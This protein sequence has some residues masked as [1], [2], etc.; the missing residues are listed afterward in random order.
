MKNPFR[1]ALAKGLTS[2]ALA[3]LVTA[4]A[5][6][7]L[8]DARQMGQAGQYESAMRTLRQALAAR[9]DDRELRTAL[10]K[11]QE[12]A[13]NELSQQAGMLRAAGQTADAR[14][15]LERLEVVAPQHP[16]TAALRAELERAARLQGM[17]A[18]G[19]RHFE[20]ARYEQAEATL[21]A[22]LA[23]DGANHAAR[24]LLTRIDELR[25]SQT[26]QRSTLSL[27]TSQKPV[28]LEFRDAALRNVF[29]ALARAADLNFVFDKDVRADARLTLFLK[30]TTV[31]E[32][33]RVILGTQQLGHKL[34]NAN[35]VMVFPATQQKQRD[36]LDT[37][38]RTF[39][40][41]NADVKQA[42]ALVRTVAKSR[43]VFIDERLNLLVVRD[44]PEVVQLID[45]LV[46][47]LDLPDPE[48]VLDLEVMEVSSKRMS[49]I[50][51][52]WPEA[53]NYGL[54]GETGPITLS[55]NLNDTLR[56]Y[57]PNPLAVAQ[58]RATQGATNLL[59][60]PR[61]RARNREKAKVL[62]GEKLP[63][64]TTT[65]TANVGVSASVSYLD[66][67]LKLEIEPQVQLDND[68]T[69]KVALEVSS[70]TD[71]VTGPQ[72]SIAYQVG[73]RQASTTLRLKDGETQILAG[74]IN[75]NES[76]TA[77]GIPGLKDLP[78]AGRLFSTTNDSRDK[79]EVVLLVTPRIV[80]NIVQP[81]SA[82][83]P[84]PSGTESQPGA[85]PMQLRDMAM[86]S[87]EGPPAGARTMTAPPSSAP[88]RPGAPSRGAAAEVSANGIGLS[89]PQQVMPGSAFR[90]TVR[91]AGA[92][93]VNETVQFDP[94]YLEAVEGDRALSSIG[95]QLPA[96]GSATVML[97]AKAGLGDFETTVQLRSGATL[98]LQVK[99]PS[100]LADEAVPEPEGEQT[101]HE[102]AVQN[103]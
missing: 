66:V 65:S 90:L 84:L 21:R 3:L 92:Q 81:V 14:R 86:M 85:M 15:V 46:Q 68:V 49:Q 36:V 45:R 77:A 69:M 6:P 39:Y 89:G 42:Q 9:P 38:T 70:V 88:D 67:G 4:C 74:L 80:R 101:E 99:E 5:S 41:T 48:V 44:T 95:V 72:G 22:L 7:A 8:E 12:Q 13:V 16:R 78:L 93:P 30:N 73:T 19:R 55:R 97:R 103:P 57:V 91:N 54:P 102:P 98:R 35:T 1:L 62:L 58:L 20:A 32:A 23:E 10:F 18:E 71:K 56:Y 96:T 25:A 33:L 61:I 47:G 29:E 2:L 24:D 59:A 87:N 94:T 82:A 50:G 64:F 17:L 60:N 43:D 53:V 51:I 83:S 34:L 27:A 28:T 52:N 100:S 31:E 75:D 79:T 76:R 37:V 63:V 11:Q 26:R 40:L